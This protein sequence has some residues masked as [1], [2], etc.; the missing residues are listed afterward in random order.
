[1]ASIYEAIMKRRSIRS[2]NGKEISSSDIEKLLIAASMAPSGKNVQPWSFFVIHND[3][4]LLKKVSELSSYSNWL[5]TSSCL[6]VIFLD[7]KS[8]RHY[9]TD[10]LAIG[11]SFQNILLSAYEMGIGSC[12]IGDVINKEAQMFSLLGIQSEG[13]EI[14][15]MISLGYTNKYRQYFSRKK[16]E[17]ILVG[18]K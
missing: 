9:L 14:M 6:I 18:W 8:S 13:L 17:E 3:K 5:K 12:W 2:Y 11:A 4:E 15:G 1:M 10:V 16:M 7:K